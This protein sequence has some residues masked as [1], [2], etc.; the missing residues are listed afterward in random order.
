MLEIWHQWKMTSSTKDNWSL[1]M[2]E[3]SFHL[4]YYW[5]FSS[6]LTSSSWARL[7][8]INIFILRGHNV[9]ITSRPLCYCAI[10]PTQSSS[11]LQ[12]GYP[13]NV[14]SLLYCYFIL[15]THKSIPTALYFPALSCSCQKSSLNKAYNKFT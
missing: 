2:C 12:C 3:I 5:F 8:L 6:T 13:I 15:P 10:V 11:I 14:S 9:L 4:N 7:I 1:P